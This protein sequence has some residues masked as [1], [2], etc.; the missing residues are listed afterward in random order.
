MAFYTCL[1]THIH[2][3]A[4]SIVHQYIWRAFGVCHYSFV[5]QGHKPGLDT[6]GAG[7]AA[8]ECPQVADQ[9]CDKRRGHAGTGGGTRV[10][11]R[12]PASTE[13]LFSGRKNVQLGAP[14]ASIDV[15]DDLGTPAVG[16]RHTDRNR[17]GNARWAEVCCR[18]VGISGRRYTDN[19]LIPG[20]TNCP[21][22]ASGGPISRCDFGQFT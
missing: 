5:T 4:A 1:H 21:F 2:L 7:K 10:S 18:R 17:L 3:P 11:V 8:L 6:T 14:V 19:A 20:S 13:N 22:E 16:A 12:P 15:R 9:A